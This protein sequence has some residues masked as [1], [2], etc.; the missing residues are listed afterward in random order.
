M[1]NILSPITTHHNNKSVAS[2]TTACPTGCVF[3]TPEHAAHIEA[4]SAAASR[5]V[6]RSSR[7]FLDKTP[8][9]VFSPISPSYNSPEQMSLADLIAQ[10]GTS[11]SV[12][13]LDGER[14]KIWRPSQPIPESEFTPVQ[15]YIE[16]DPFIFAWGNPL[17]SSPAALEKTARAFIAFAEATHHRPVWCC[18]DRNLEAVLA[19]EA[20][21]WVTM[22]CIY[23]DVMDPAHVI[24]I[25][26][27]QHH[28]DD[29]LKKNLAHA[30]KDHVEAREVKYGEWNPI[31]REM[32]EAGIRD[33]KAHKL[34]MEFESMTI[35]PWLDEPHRRYWVAKRQ[36]KVVGI[37][38]LSRIS[39]T[40]WQI[41]KCITFRHATTG[42]SEKLIFTALKD[43]YNE[44]TE[45][46]KE[47]PS[48]AVVEPETTAATTPATTAGEVVVEPD[49]TKDRVMVSFGITAAE[50]LLPGHNVCG[51]KISVL[52]RTYNAVSGMV[53]LIKTGQYRK[54]F[55]VTQEPMYVCYPA[56]HFGFLAVGSLLMALRK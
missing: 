56:N 51:W 53:G 45:L 6:S 33:W 48:I 29:E 49:R 5:S 9:G 22:S 20:L 50:H 46:A 14:Y 8:T 28:D 16:K 41:V 1:A 39:P 21:G 12:A 37:E 52:S 4:A 18:V 55:E 47:A 24:E 17:V 10:Y 26:D 43:L 36:G 34:G 42:V 7:E 35:E 44:Q 32:V 23:D 27:L 13:W 31:E 30:E 25:M 38:I 3:G 15:G 11:S 40:S 19:N 54:K 2:P